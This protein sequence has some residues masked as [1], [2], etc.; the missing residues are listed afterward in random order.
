MDFLRSVG[1]KVVAGVVAVVVV[2]AAISWF[3]TDA[4][5]R[6]TII[7]GAGKI[8]SWFG[9]V[10]L[11]PWASFFLIGRVARLENNPAGAALVLGYTAIEATVLAWLFGWSVGGATA[12]VFYAAAVLL[13]GVYNLLACDWIAEKAA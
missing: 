13:A 2:A 1:G 9:V 10:L 7:A 12:W 8:A 6:H 5:T 4:A 11:V 3:Q